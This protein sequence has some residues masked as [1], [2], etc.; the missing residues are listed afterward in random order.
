MYVCTYVCVPCLSMSVAYRN[1]RRTLE[2]LEDLEMTVSCS[3]SS[4][5]R[6]Q[7]SVAVTGAPNYLA[8]S[9]DPILTVCSLL[10]I[11]IELCIV[12]GALFCFSS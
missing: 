4:G 10:E 1:E 6:T 12:F 9:T 2:P 11:Q 8:I 3:V 5:N 7:F